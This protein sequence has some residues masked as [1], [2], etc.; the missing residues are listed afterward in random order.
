MGAK[1]APSWWNDGLFNH[2]IRL[3]FDFRCCCMRDAKVFMVKTEMISDVIQFVVCEFFYC[4][5]EME[6]SL[7]A[8]AFVGYS[9]PSEQRKK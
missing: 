6:G 8:F 7:T 2:P 1:F 5:L 9:A 4:Y 3:F